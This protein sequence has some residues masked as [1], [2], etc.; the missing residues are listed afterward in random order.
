MAKFIHVIAARPNFIKAAPLIKAMRYSSLETLVVHTVQHYDPNMSDTFLNQLGILPL[1]YH[2]TCGVGSHAK[3]VGNTMIEL[4]Q[5]FLKEKPKGVIVYGDVNSTLAASLAASKIHIP[6]IHVESGCRSY[7]NT[8]PEEINRI[9]VD[10]IANILFTTSE[11]ALD[12]LTKEGVD[13]S[14]CFFVGNTMIDSLVEFQNK[15]LSSTILSKLDLKPKKYNLCT[16]HRPS[17]V[18][19]KVVLEELMNSLVQIHQET[20]CVLPLHPRTKN[21]LKKY[22]LYD[23]Y[24]NLLKFIPPQGYFDFMCLQ[25]NAYTILTDS[26]GIQEESSYFNVP[27][28][29]LRTSTERPVTITNGTNKLIGVDYSN[30][31]KE[32]QNINRNKKSHLN[33]WDGK[34]SR[35]IIQVLKNNFK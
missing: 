19:N 26:G 1:D 25:Q 22:K 10:R 13:P 11:D 29:T 24:S 30:L 18:D 33:L 6:I 15:F 35:R 8:M 16:F 7:D 14:K 9:L 28:L 23:K 20:P 3:Q 34:T 31:K 4:E 21:N 27:C 2:L 32:Y 17:N 5:I 12:N